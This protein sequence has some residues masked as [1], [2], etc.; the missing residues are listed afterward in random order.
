MFTLLVDGRLMT[1]GLTTPPSVAPGRLTRSMDARCISDDP[2]PLAKALRRIAHGLARGSPTPSPRGTRRLRWPPASWAVSPETLPFIAVLRF[3]FADADKRRDPGRRGRSRTGDRLSTGEAARDHQGLPDDAAAPRREGIRRLP[4]T[5][6]ERWSRTASRAARRSAG[7]VPL[8][9]V[10]EINDLYHGAA[11]QRVS[12]GV[13]PG[14]GIDP[15]RKKRKLR[16][17]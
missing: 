14:S 5:V 1:R 11:G 10:C 12:E 13:R 6:G 17:L 9:H 4:H 15:G 16:A 8:R 7:S 3:P 2:R